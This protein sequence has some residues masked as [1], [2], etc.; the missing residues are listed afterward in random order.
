MGCVLVGGA[1][2]RALVRVTLGDGPGIGTLGSGVVENHGR[3]TL[4][5][6]VSLASRF[7]V[8]L[9]SIGRRISHSC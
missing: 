5:D 4:S 9:R 2:L 1:I 3:T 8:H 6:G 7:I